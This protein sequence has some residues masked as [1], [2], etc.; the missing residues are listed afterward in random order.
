LIAVTEIPKAM[1]ACESVLSKWLLSTW[2]S[3]ITASVGAVSHDPILRRGMTVYVAVAIASPDLVADSLSPK[4]FRRCS[5]IF[6]APPFDILNFQ[7]SSHDTPFRD[8][9]TRAPTFPEKWMLVQLYRCTVTFQLIIVRSFVVTFV[10]QARHSVTASSDDDA[11]TSTKTKSPRP[12][13][14]A[15]YSI[16]K[17]FRVFDNVILAIVQATVRG[18]IGDW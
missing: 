15:S 16:L 9:R 2:S 8:F 1:A 12:T 10:P 13:I 14:Q 4:I 17:T 7:N 3:S 6:C 11:A 18:L 5:F